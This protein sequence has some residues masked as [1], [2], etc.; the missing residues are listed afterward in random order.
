MATADFFTP[1]VDDPRTWGRIA[2]VNAVSDVYAMGGQPLFGLNL[3]AWPREKLPTDLLVEVLEGGAEAAEAGGWIVAGGH[4]VDGTEPMYGQSIVGE[5]APDDVLTNVGASPGEAIVL[6]KP[7]GSGIVATAVKRLEPADVQIG[8]E[9]HDTYESAVAEM[10]RLNAEAADVARGVAASTCT[11]VTGFGLLGH[12]HKLLAASGAA[13]EVT[14]DQVPV[15]DGVRELLAAGYVPGGTRR[16]ANWVRQH[17]DG[18]V[19]D[20]DLTLLA[21]AQTSGGLLFTCAM[22]VAEDA[23]EQ[24]RSNGHTA[25]VIGVVRDGGAGRMTIRG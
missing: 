17:L 16:N 3:V 1:I 7:I 20:D 24:L 8:G 22:S 14:L 12:L 5:I 9:W 13:A 19:R 25:A 4:T 23:A 2:A 21:D 10:V 18:D 6:T 11:D 15:I